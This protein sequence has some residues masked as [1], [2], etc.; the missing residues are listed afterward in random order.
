[1]RA[2]LR[3]TIG[4]LALVAT[5]ALLPVAMAWLRFVWNSAAP[6]RAS[7]RPGHG[8]ITAAKAMPPSGD[9]FATYS[10]LGAALGRQYVH[11]A[12]ARTLADAFAR[13]AGQKPGRRFQLAETGWRHGGR[14][15]P[16]R[17]HQNGL[18]VDILVPAMDAAGHPQTL[19]TWPWQLF[20][21]GWEF[22]AAGESGDLRIDF[23]SLAQLLLA[24]DAAA[25]PH[26]LRI[27]LII[28]AP[29]YLPRLLMTPPGHRLEPLRG[30]FMRHAAWIRHDEHVHVD[31][32]PTK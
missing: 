4:F 10:Y 11:G 5:L 23:E 24:L 25:P 29:E 14:F 28:V 6:S 18:S 9:G 22:D 16:H 8:H 19:S 32:A 17:T 21:Y 27:E 26:G 31:F 15:R 12:V 1:M 2:R 20:G 30:R 13:A 3:R 7:G